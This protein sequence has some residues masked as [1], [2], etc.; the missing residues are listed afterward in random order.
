MNVSVLNWISIRVS[1][2]N[3][4]FVTNKVCARCASI[5]KYNVRQFSSTMWQ[6]KQITRLTNFGW[7][8]RPLILP[9]FKKTTRRIYV[10][11]FTGFVGFCHLATYRRKCECQTTCSMCS[12]T[13]FERKKETKQ[14]RPKKWRPCCLLI[15]LILSTILAVEDR[16]FNALL[17]GYC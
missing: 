5:K 17:N 16:I 14:W 12:L 6:Y 10:Q 13:L 2:C 3:E 15:T 9:N 11:H 4:S 7:L 1:I 8:Q